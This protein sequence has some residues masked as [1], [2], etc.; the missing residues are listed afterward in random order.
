MAVL[1]VI[2]MSSEYSG[3]CRAV[4]PSNLQPLY[5]HFCS[6]C[7]LPSIKNTFK[8]YQIRNR[9]R[10][11][12]LYTVKLLSP[13]KIQTK[14]VSI[15]NGIFLRF[16]CLV[17]NVR[18]SSFFGNAFGTSSHSFEHSGHWQ[19]LE[20]GF[21]FIQIDNE[22]FETRFDR[23]DRWFSSMTSKMVCFI[24]QF[25]KGIQKNNRLPGLSK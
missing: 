21:Y 2:K 22:L 20:D 13:E 4:F 12:S 9:K 24:K 6:L 10:Y 7:S 15:S 14:S 8:H 16:Q 18:D 5:K 1:F 19:S 3:I 11:V 25:L 23:W 17:Q